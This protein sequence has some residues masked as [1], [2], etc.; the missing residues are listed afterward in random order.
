M[1]GEQRNQD[2][3]RVDAVLGS[4]RE[5]GANLGQALGARDGSERSGDLLL[6]YPALG[7]VSRRRFWWARVL[8]A[9]EVTLKA[10]DDGGVSC[11]F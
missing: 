10:G 2:V 3:H 9:S 6:D 11:R 4:S 5:V 1:S 7:V 8:E